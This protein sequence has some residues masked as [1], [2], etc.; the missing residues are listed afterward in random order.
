MGLGSLS[1]RYEI[2]VFY[3]H[4]RFLIGLQEDQ[5]CRVPCVIFPS[6]AICLMVCDTMSFQLDFRN[7]LQYYHEKFF[8][9]IRSM[10]R[11]RLGEGA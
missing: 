8:T 4:L 10:H 7:Q 3:S 9:S 11:K 1:S 2:L 5:P 6:Q